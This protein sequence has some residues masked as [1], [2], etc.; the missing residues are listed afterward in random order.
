MPFEIGSR[1][2]DYAILGR[3]GAGGEGR[4][5]KARHVVTGRVEAL[6]VLQVD[7]EESR[8]L[9]DRFLR[10]I[11]VH[12][13]LQHP[14]IASVYSAFRSDGRLVMAMELVDGRTLRELMKSGKVDLASVLDYA[15]QS[16]D[17]LQYAHTREVI[18][19]D[20]KPENIL[21]TPKGQVK[22]TDFGLA[23][24]L[25]WESYTQ[26]S[27]PMGSLRYMSPEQVRA[28]KD[29]DGRS[30]LYSLGVVLYELGVGKPPFG[31]DNPFDLMKAHVETIPRPPSKLNTSLPSE[32]D[33][34]ILKALR[35]EPAQRFASSEE[36]REALMRIGTAVQDPKPSP[37]ADPKK[38]RKV[39]GGLKRGRWLAT[40]AGL[41]LGMGVATT[42]LLWPS[43][44]DAPIPE[45]PAIPAPASPP[46]F[47]YLRTPEATGEQIAGSRAP[48]PRRPRRTTAPP[49]SASSDNNSKVVPL[50][51][52]ENDTLD[53]INLATISPITRTIELAPIS[54]AE[55][56][57][58]QLQEPGL[59]LL[60]TLNGDKT[61]RKIIF[62]S[63]NQYIATIGNT[64]FTV[65]NQTTGAEIVSAQTPKNR[66]GA[67][68]FSPQGNQFFA[69]YADGNVK[70]WDLPE[71]REKAV[72]GHNTSVTA[73]GLSPKGDLLMVGLLNKSIHL[74]RVNPADGRFIRE[75]RRLRGSKLSPMAID[76]SADANLVTA[77]SRDK[78]LVTWRLPDGKAERIPSLTEGASAVAFSPQG[79]VVAASARGELGIWHLESRKRIV[80]LPIEGHI[81]GLNFTSEGRC[82]AIATNDGALTIWDATSSETV[83]ALET[84]AQY[85]AAAISKDGQR[86]AAIDS[87]GNLYLW[88]MNS[89]GASRIAKS[90]DTDEMTALLEAAPSVDDPGEEQ[91]GVLRRIFGAVW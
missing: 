21:I 85:R 28:E 27:A 47:A 59:W 81:H 44:D 32:L 12:A 52:L 31:A 67:L 2:G 39:Q 70:V 49:Q 84:G 87:A 50:E 56:E 37:L 35:K 64:S 83:T 1:V 65:W 43:A 58:V 62:D 48:A 7:F 91:K 45:L 16:L 6:K 4:I 77:V 30:D 74:W 76:Y 68:M 73:L 71:G 24:I 23:K 3:V 5:F 15:S 33:S 29:L 82:Y 72:L 38:P 22:L 75:Q 63:Q 26:S 69:G 8:D 17:A 9:A 18:H 90:I 60:R 10:E 36:F 55:P 54:P 51:N 42:F 66:I 40:A 19:R 57:P 13:S 20:I 88:Q 14:N 61:A 78:Q 89:A 86:V 53:E 79:T 34:V 25:S 46:D 41:L 80:T 11:R